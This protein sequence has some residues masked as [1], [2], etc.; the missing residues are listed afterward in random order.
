[1]TNLF[2]N[3]VTSTPLMG[4]TSG[5]Q[6]NRHSGI[7]KRDLKRG[8]K[9]GES[10]HSSPLSLISESKAQSPLGWTHQEDAKNRLQHMHHFTKATR[11]TLGNVQIN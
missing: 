8:F 6:R 5:R 11:K 2:S 3:R 7:D 1:M 4:R 10:Q 9:P